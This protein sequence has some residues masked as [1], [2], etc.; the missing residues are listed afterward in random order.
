MVCYK[1]EDAL[2]MDAKTEKGEK[3][4]KALEGI[5]EEADNKAVAEQQKVTRERMAKLPLAN[6]KADAFGDGKTKEFFDLPRMEGAF[7]KLPRLRHMHL[8]VPH[9]PVLRY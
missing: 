7:R 8:C 6:L 2:Y 5:T 1:T 4:L 9:L 3:L